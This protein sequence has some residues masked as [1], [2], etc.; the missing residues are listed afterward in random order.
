[1]AVLYIH[2]RCS[3]TYK[4]MMVSVN[5]LKSCVTQLQTSFD[6]RFLSR[7]LCAYFPF[8]VRMQREE[9]AI[10]TKAAAPQLSEFGSIVMELAATRGIK[11]QAA[12]RRALGCVGYDIP[13][14]TLSGYL[15]GKV[16]VDPDLPLALSIALSL[17]QRDKR[18]LADAFTFVQ[19][20]RRGSRRVSDR[21]LL[22]NE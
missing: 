22:T 7:I 9:D 5:T 14:R 18:A 17:G 12:L 1:M 10:N 2:F 21:S 19:P 15:H 4:R 8:G 16:V 13:E 3:A 11:T 6:N 20:P